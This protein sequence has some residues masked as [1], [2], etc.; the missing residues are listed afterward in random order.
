[1]PMDL[2]IDA[3]SEALRLAVRV[4]VP[5]SGR[6]LTRAWPIPDDDSLAPLDDSLEVWIAA[7]DEP[8]RGYQLVFN[9]RG[10]VWDAIH[11]R[12][13][14][15]W[16]V[17][18]EGRL[19]SGLLTRV[20]DT[21]WTAELSLP[22]RL[23]AEGGAK[24]PG[25][26]KLAVARQEQR[27]LRRSVWPAEFVESF[28]SA[29]RV[30]IRDDAVVAA[31]GETG[32]I[33]ANHANHPRDLRVDVE[34]S[35][36]CS[37]LDGR[38]VRLNGNEREVVRFSAECHEADARVDV[39]EIADADL[40]LLSVQIPPLATT[41]ASTSLSS[42]RGVRFDVGYYPYHGS[43]RVRLDTAGA[44]PPMAA[45]RPKLRVL[46]AA[47][48]DA[49]IERELDV[50]PDQPLQE[51]F[52]LP[53]LRDGRYRA[54]VTFESGDGDPLVLEEAFDKRTFGW[55]HNRLGLEDAVIPP[56]EPLRAEGDRVSA[57]LRDHTIGPSGLFDEIESLGT[58]LLASQMRF[59][60][61][62]DG[63]VVTPAASGPLRFTRRSDTEVAWQL[64]WVAGSLE[65]RTSSTMEIDGLVW[66]AIELPAQ[67]EARIERLDLV[68]PLRAEIA[69][70]MNVVTDRTRHN[71]SGE[72]PSGQGV[73]WESRDANRVELGGT[74]VPYLW[75][76]DER[77]GLAWFASGTED[78]VLEP[79][80]SVQW[81]ERSPRETV[82]R[83]RLIGR[84]TQLDRPRRIVMGL[85]ATP[86]KPTM[87]APSWRL[88]QPYCVAE[89]PTRSLCILGSGWEWGAP[90]AFGDYYVAEGNE[91]ILL[92]LAKA[93]QSGRFRRGSIDEWL[94][95]RKAQ[96]PRPR[97]V[98]R[99]LD[100]GFRMVAEN[101]DAVVAY[102]N[103]H[104]IRPIAESKVYRHEWSPTPFAEDPPP[105]WEIE[106]RYN[107][108]PTKS[109][110][111]FATWNLK[112][113]I[114]AG[115]ADGF[116]FDDTYL[117]AVFD[118]VSGGAHVS[119][120]GEL[121]PVVDLMELRQFLK[122]LQ[123]MAYHETG[124]WV[125]VTHMTNTPIAPLHTWSGAVLD[126]EL[127]FG[128][129]PFPE[130]F[131]RAFLRAESLGTQV[132]SLPLFLAGV[133]GIAS[134]QRRREVELTA[135][136]SLAVHEIRSWAGTERFQREIWTP[137]YEFGY[138]SPETRVLRYWDE[139]SRFRISG[140]DAE[141]IVL[142]RDAEALALVSDFGGEGGSAVIEFDGRRLGLASDGRCRV[143]ASRGRVRTEAPFRCR[144][145]LP[146]YGSRLIS[147]VS[148]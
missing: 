14:G 76:G 106:A 91:G 95:R 8:Q 114:D 42:T 113:L 61:R 45:A 84:S 124:Q 9:A 10:A 37:S 100:Y 68:I 90:T 131:T 36:G 102:V 136:A 23:L 21:H 7:G 20:S 50:A 2:W 99:S 3:D 1:M 15:E 31:F 122:R 138:G 116:Y 64:D 89:P 105:G 98:R 128:P 137:L 75:L 110:Q 96:H 74:L 82:L 39:V 66:L 145:E 11:A 48:S 97:A 80:A 119:D 40:D 79:G 77:R 63:E 35:E 46:G 107:T 133:T 5:P 103:A 12:D 57:V 94:R 41:Q 129:E 148:D 28:D 132:G 104:H 69:R 72:T 32:L 130:R 58:Q 143:A 134:K 67:A 101:P 55:E 86:T 85:Q 56:F 59:E 108:F 47:N 70:L 54:R 43:L 139:P 115:V 83:V 92:A 73:V 29:S 127:R 147:W 53:A 16:V 52:D 87:P 125:N 49:V 93:R 126:G 118:D 144:F 117:R 146:A 6:L 18:S 4:P 109:F 26:V 142:V 27:P 78:W 120:G 24:P 141:A 25:V 121:Q 81:V 71:F 62:V 88:W 140:V 60:L 17:R 112:R 111:D 33:L 135:V 34:P 51:V 19:P 44:D 22:W 30:E 38:V 13:G 123:T 65:G